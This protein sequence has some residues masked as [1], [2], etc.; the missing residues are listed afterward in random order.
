MELGE[1][2]VWADGAVVGAVVVVVVELVVDVWARSGRP[3]SVSAVRRRAFIKSRYALLPP[4]QS[5][6][7][8]GFWI[9]VIFRSDDLRGRL[10]NPFQ[11]TNPSPDA[12]RRHPWLGAR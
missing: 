3:A 1:G 10:I 11:K 6:S 4:W 12:Q 7:A 9:D 2:G 5:P 8:A